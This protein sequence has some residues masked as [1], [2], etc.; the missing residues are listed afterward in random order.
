M[1]E[2]SVDEIIVALDDGSDPSV[3]T[4]LLEDTASMAAPS[5]LINSI[6]HSLTINSQHSE[7]LER[8]SCRAYTRY[9]VKDF[10]ESLK[11]SLRAVDAVVTSVKRY[12]DRN[13]V[14]H[15]FLILQVS[16]KAGRDFYL[17]VD[18][19]PDRR[20]PLL[21]FS[22]KSGVS[23]AEDTVAISGRPEHLQDYT[24]AEE[25]NMVLSTGA[26][27]PVIG[28]ILHAVADESQQYSF[29]SVSMIYYIRKIDNRVWRVRRL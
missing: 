16:R 15:R 25:A 4:G 9:R 27:L 20:I 11:H 10:C 23:D 22:S 12:G 18:R 1:G 19:R 2:R 14:H 7:L 21:R 6:C 26:P 24:S 8:I 5:T 17:R 28:Q 29:T 3:S 13:G